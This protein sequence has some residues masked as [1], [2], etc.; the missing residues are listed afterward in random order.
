MSEEKPAG[1]TWWSDR[2]ELVLH[3]VAVLLGGVLAVLTALNQPY[4]QNEWVQIAPYDSWDPAVVTSGTRQP[5]L[6]PILGSL[7]QHAVG[8][9]HL[10]QRIVPIACGVGLMVVM[11]AL[12]RRLR[13]GPHGVLAL[14]VMATAPVFLRFAAYTRPYAL[15]A[16]LMLLC[17]WAA[18]RWL[19][20]GRRRWLVAAV[21][22]GFLLPLSRVPEPVVFLGSS[23]VL[24][25]LAGWR[26]WLPRRE[27]WWLGGGWLLALVSVGATSA[28]ALGSHTAK[29]TGRSLIDLDPGNAL[30]RLPTG[31]RELRDY[32]LPLYAD[33][34]PWW[35]VTVLVVVLALA[36]PTSRR[37]LLR[38]WWWWPL[39]LAPLAFLV[40]YHTVNPFPLDV[41][42]YRIRFAYFWIP[43][44]VVLVALAS[45]AVARSWRRA[46]A[47][48]GPLL[49]VAL[50]VSQ[51]PT[52]WRV[53]TDNDTVDLGQAA[54]T[55][56]RELPADAVVIYDG[57]APIG[58]WRQPFFGSSRLF[59]GPHARV[60]TPNRIAAGRVDVGAAAGP[61]HLLLLDSTCVNSVACDSTP[62]EWSGDVAG[63]EAVDRFDR[64]T[65][66]APVDG[67]AGRE[68]AI[69]AL[70][71]LAEAYG[72]EYGVPDAAAAA[73]L[74]VA[75]GR[76]D[77]AAA[78][79]EQTCAAQPADQV[80]ACR[81]EMAEADPLTRSRQ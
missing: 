81:D 21:V 65:L 71:A 63:W 79:V 55:I 45:Q 26:R 15:P 53:L 10:Q 1:R 59:E 74:L 57:P 33:W 80:G 37:N 77:E 20:T 41:R 54:A 19:D 49:V 13:L 18:T 47:W 34:F 43:P 17:V 3:G 72:P 31:L 69:E 5:P 58:Y 24:L 42:H 9:G 50:L 44:L 78:L 38:T 48:A 62:V 56:E 27:A 75:A 28:L 22:A 52:T 68:G 61:V 16:F 40:A 39:L 29:R 73:R 25:V 6:D 4:N 2:L 12:L 76:D 30:A 35:P 70:T 64:F 14:F 46:G 67:Q 23:V 32:V 7:V 36:L 8:V 66:Y 11:A 60:V 51:L